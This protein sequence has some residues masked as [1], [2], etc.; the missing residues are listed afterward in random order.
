MKDIEQAGGL[1]EDVIVSIMH[2]EKGNQTEQFKIP[3]KLIERFFPAGTKA[4]DKQETIVKALELYR[5]HE[6]SHQP[7]EQEQ[8]RERGH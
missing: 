2:E 6:K 5:A 7:H 3:A 4:K 1:A 8:E